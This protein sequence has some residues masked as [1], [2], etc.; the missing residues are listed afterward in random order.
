SKN[1]KSLGG[2]TARRLL[3]GLVKA[4]ARTETGPR[5]ISKSPANSPRW[6]LGVAF[7][8][9]SVPGKG[10]PHPESLGDRRKVKRSC[11]GHRNAGARD[12]HPDGRPR[13]L[14]V[15]G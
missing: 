7:G 15:G 4:L 10:Q 9:L 2:G 12:H 13:R 3:N 5:G 11:A 6:R 8:A 14:R 1:G